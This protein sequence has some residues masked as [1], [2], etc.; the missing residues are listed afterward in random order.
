M[1][2]TILAGLSALVLCGAGAVA[3][4]EFEVQM[5]NR[6]AEGT[7]VFEPAFLQIQPGDSVRFVPTDRGH[8]AESVRGMTPEGAEPFKGRINEEITVTFD[9]E[10]AYG[11]MCLPHFAMGM[12]GLIVVGDDPQNID[13]FADV[14][15]TPKARQRFDGYIAQIGG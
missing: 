10:G 13:A 11:Y 15:M 1:R 6:G 2:T 14:R 7:M 8:N 9:V 4:E 12:V 5:L 3:A